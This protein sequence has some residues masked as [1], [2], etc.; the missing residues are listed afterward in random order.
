MNAVCLQCV[1]DSEGAVDRS[2]PAAPNSHSNH[3]TKPSRRRPAGTSKLNGASNLARSASCTE[4][5]SRDKTSVAL[6]KMPPGGTHLCCGCSHMVAVAKG[7]NADMSMPCTLRQKFSLESRQAPSSSGASCSRQRDGSIKP[8]GFKYLLRTAI[9]EGN[10]FSKRSAYP[11][12]SLTITS[13]TLSLPRSNSSARH[14]LTSTTSRASALA[15]T[16]CRRKW[17]SREAS[18]ATTRFAP[19]RALKIASRPV[20]E[21][22]SITVVPLLPAHSFPWNSIACRYASTRG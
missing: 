2:H 4:C 3:A 14:S 16:I 6:P 18:T 12:H 1:A 11:I 10:M 8:S 20:P 13:A 21:P 7:T 15:S 9:T 22:T 5:K 17:A 19:A